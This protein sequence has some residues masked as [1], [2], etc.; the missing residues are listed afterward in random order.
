M[1]LKLD[2]EV[3]VRA[4]AEARK[5]PPDDA[6]HCVR[7]HASANVEVLLAVE[8]WRDDAHAEDHVDNVDRFGGVKIAARRSKR[9]PVAARMTTKRSRGAPDLSACRP[10]LLREA[11]CRRR[12]RPE[13]ALRA[14]A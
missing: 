8:Q 10:C 13:C 5:S 9:G 12:R 2:V 7:L 3:A 1:N 6:Q 14:S 4:S 11:P